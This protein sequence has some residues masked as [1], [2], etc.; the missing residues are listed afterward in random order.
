MLKITLRCYKHPNFNPALSG[1]DDIKGG[2]NHCFQ[3][4]NLYRTI[5]DVQ[6][7]EDRKL[8]DAADRLI[9][10]PLILFFRTKRIARRS[11]DRTSPAKQKQ[12]SK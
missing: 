6:R 3:L 9:P 5:Q 2:C 7:T 10:M 8:W 4:S 12:L 11:A 1:I